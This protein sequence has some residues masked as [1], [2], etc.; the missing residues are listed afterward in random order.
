MKIFTIIG[1][2]PQFVKCAPV[3][4]ALRKKHSEFLVHT[5]Q[6]YDENMSH[7]F[8]DEM[9]IPK[10]D[11]NLDVGSGTHATQTAAMMTGLEPLMLEQKPDSVMIYGDTNSTV[12]GALVAAKLHI[13]VIHIEA[14]LRSFNLKMPEEINRIVADRLSKI[15]CCPTNTAVENLENEGIK[16]GVINTGD[17]MYDAVLM[18]KP[19]SE[20]S[21][22][23]KVL[24]LKPK[25]YNLITIHRASNTDNTENLLNILNGANDSGIKSVFPIHPRTKNI[26]KNNGISIDSFQNINFIAPLGYLDFMALAANAKTITTDSGGLQKEAYWHGVPCITVRKETEWVETVKSGWNLLIGPNREKLTK[27][28]HEFAPSCERPDFYGNGHASEKIVEAIN[29]D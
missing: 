9:G 18:F 15:L 21:E 19:L 2:R 11:V 10:P 13:P 20:K 3:S 28:L 25:E 12:A 22:Y 27:A 24:G 17:V 26:M 5:G 1:A 6:H 7:I 14:G 23:P 29:L 8:F 4:A 16:N